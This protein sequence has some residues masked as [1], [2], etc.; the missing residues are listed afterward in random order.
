MQGF[1]TTLE[2]LTAY[3]DQYSIDQIQVLYQEYAFTPEVQ[4][5]LRAYL[6]NRLRDEVN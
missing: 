3:L 6:F 2:E 1:P 4:T 5:A